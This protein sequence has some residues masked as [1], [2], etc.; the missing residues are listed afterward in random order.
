MAL[1]LGFRCVDF[2]I[3]CIFPIRRISKKKHDLYIFLC[4]FMVII[5]WYLSS[6]PTEFMFCYDKSARGYLTFF[7]GVLLYEVYTRLSKDS[8]RR[9][10][11]LLFGINIIIIMVSGMFW[12]LLHDNVFG[13][14]R[15]FMSVYFIP[16]L[17]F[18]SIYLLGDFRFL[19]SRR[20]VKYMT[21]I[22]IWHALVMAE[23]ELVRVYFGITLDYSN[24]VRFSIVVLIIALQ[25]IV[26]YYLI[27]KRM[28]KYI[29]CKIEK[30]VVFTNTE[31]T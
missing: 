10:S 21:S 3:Y 27:E 16:S 20:I 1:E 23:I 14:F 31:N 4:S 19:L 17:I 26:S 18:L 5:G 6:N 24:W 29:N 25:C 7:I 15:I 12:L 11:L 22:Y 8:G 28:T 2:I 30:Y 13:S 9:I